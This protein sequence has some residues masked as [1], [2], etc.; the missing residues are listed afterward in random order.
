[1]TDTVARPA[2]H[3]VPADAF[4]AVRARWLPLVALLALV[5]LGV[6]AALAGDAP[7]ELFLVLLYV[8]LLAWTG[9][10]AWRHGIR[11]RTFFRRPRIGRYWVVVA[12]MTV[13]LFVFS[14]G[15]SSITS[16]LLP[17]YTDQAQVDA[18]AGVPILALSLVILPPVIEELVFRGM[19]LERWAVKWR[20]G[21]AVVVQAV[22]FGILHVD[23]VGAGVF[24]VVM[25]LM[26]VRCRSLWVPMAM[27]A[28]NNG[29]VLLAVLL[30]GDAAADTTAPDAVTAIVTGLVALAV[31][32]PFVALFVWRN[33][34][35]AQSL[36]PYEV[37]EFGDTALPPRHL[38]AVTV[39][40][41]PYGIAGQRGRLWLQQTGITVMAGRISRASLTSAPYPAVAGLEVAPDLAWIRLVAH[42][43]AVLQLRF[44]TRTRRARQGAVA[45]LQERLAAGATG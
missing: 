36:T 45:A 22:A 40:A 13:A 38:G 20:L 19:L 10:A 23:P 4:A 7:P 11:L 41:G 12:G 2:G 29:T 1:M 39:V 30:A 27:H 31:S 24:G 28:A 21:V 9:W 15:A 18:D 42:D 37:A 6:A 43:G 3:L 35:T 44:G 17:G 32:G 34:P 16:A 5:V 33:W 25:A 14:L 8:P 26:Y